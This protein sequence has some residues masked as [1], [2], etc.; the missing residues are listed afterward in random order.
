M[1]AGLGLIERVVY[2]TF[3]GK[4]FKLDIRYVVLN[5][6]FGDLVH[7]NFLLC[8]CMCLRTSSHQ[9]LKSFRDGSQLKISSDRPEKLGIELEQGEQFICYTMAGIFYT[10]WQK[11]NSGKLSLIQI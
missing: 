8:T 10:V 4:L 7:T 3:V 2:L 9:Q 5:I 1:L 11:T 6:V